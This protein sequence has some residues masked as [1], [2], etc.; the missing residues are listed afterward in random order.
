MVATNRE[1]P[2]SIRQALVMVAVAGLLTIACAQAQA[3][4]VAQPAEQAKPVQQTEQAKPEQKAEPAP[5]ATAAPQAPQAPQAKPDAAPSTVGQVQA[6]AAEEKFEALAD[7]CAPGKEH[8]SDP[9]PPIR[10]GIFNVGSAPRHLDPSAASAQFKS[11]MRMYEWLIKQR[12]CFGS[13]TAVVPS[14]AKS[15]EISPDGLTW[16]FKLHENVK[17]HNLPPVNGRA[18]T[19]ADVGWTLDYYAEA[20]PQRR[21]Y[22]GVT[23]SEPDPNT[24]VLKLSKPT[25]DF[26]LMLA[27]DSNAVLPHEIKEQHGDYKQIA[28]GTG[29]WQLKEYQ[30]RQYITWERNPNYYIMGA[31]GKPLPYMDE[32]RGVDL[33]DSAATFAALRTS[34]QDFNRGTSFRPP[35][36]AELQAA[37]PNGKLVPI[38][39]LTVFGLWFNHNKAPW[40]DVRVRR[41]ISMG[42][43]RDETIASDDGGSIY[44]G[45]MAVALGDFS[46]SEEKIKEKF[47]YDLPGSKKLL[48]EAGFALKEPVKIATGRGSTYGTHLEVAG[49]QFDKMGIP[50]EL[51]LAPGGKTAAGSVIRSF[52][53]DIAYGPPGACKFPTCW[54][55]EL[56]ATGPGNITQLIDPKL[57]AMAEAQARELDP[58]KRIK[59]VHAVQDYEY[60]ILPFIP[61]V[62]RLYQTWEGC[63]VK[64]MRPHHG[65]NTIWGV[66]HA[67]LDDKDC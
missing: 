58:V 60:E 2:S 61:L 4:P 56:I 53:F 33:P 3:P 34:Q 64:N 50:N 65:L 14:L 17:W 44:S 54:A 25:A 6:K 46:W 39:A 26:A 38:P 59:L 12:M 49:S 63:R 15:W 28:V 41:A 36:A 27:D 10:G 13:D 47:K 35:E 8:W 21:F 7:Q 20:S 29:A 52:E 18:F 42:F 9:G 66:Q 45:F 24:V 48:A 23:H 62:V 43:N 40:N 11:P 30:A 67:W 5:Q 19:S 51:V 1:A 22:S 57:D 32:V 37:I 16:T 31:D 55:Q